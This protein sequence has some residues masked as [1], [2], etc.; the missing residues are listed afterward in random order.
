MET[1]GSQKVRR[2]LKQLTEEF[3]FGLRIML[4]I[5]ETR[6]VDHSLVMLFVRIPKKGPEISDR[7]VDFD[8]VSLQRRAVNKAELISEFVRLEN[9]WAAKIISRI[10]TSHSG[11]LD[12]GYV[13]RLL[14]K[15]H[16]EMQRLSEEFQHGQRV[17]ELLVPFLQI[18][19]TSRISPPIRIVDLGCG[20]GFVIRWLA[21]R[22][23]L[24]TDVELIGADYNAALIEEARKLASLENL[25][26]RFEVANAF[27]LEQAPTVIIS[28]GVLHH[29]RES[30]LVDLFAFHNQKGTQGFIHF[31]F[32]SSQLAPF[33]S[34]L[35]H[36]ARMREPLAKHDGVLSAVRAHPSSRLLS[37]ARSGATDFVCAIYGTKLWGLPI[38]RAFH[39]LIGM[40]QQYSNDFRERIRP[41]IRSLGVIE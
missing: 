3:R 33:G 25:A 4:D 31:D 17:A 39:A 21:A 32:R 30:E 8:P 13:N 19:R 6:R 38:P 5:V 34:W 10:P 35:F 24:G 20:T 37:A 11:D 16:C 23:S 26:C 22:A 40:R 18:L 9:P 27:Q 7:I 2:P 14:V 36:A 29:F 1:K 15:V 12:A 41:R 28:T